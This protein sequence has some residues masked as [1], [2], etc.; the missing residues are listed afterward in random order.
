MIDRRG[1]YEQRAP[2][3]PGESNRYYQR[4]LQMALF[5]ARRL[6]FIP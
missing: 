2:L 5:A 3:Q 6:R 4:L 1:F